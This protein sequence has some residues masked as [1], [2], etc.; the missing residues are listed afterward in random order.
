MILTGMG[1]LIGALLLACALF[2]VQN[3]AWAAGPI[4]SIES[5]RGSVTVERPG[6]GLIKGTVGLSVFEDDVLVTGAGSAVGVRFI[7][8]TSFGL[9]AGGHMV[10]D[11]FAYDPRADSGQG[12]IGVVAG[13]F[14]FVSGRLGKVGDDAL[15]VDT[16]TLTL[17]IRG[18]TV[19]GRVA[20]IGGMSKAVL[21]RDQG[22]TVGKIIAYNRSGYGVL[23]DQ[24]NF[25]TTAN[26]PNKVPSEPRLF[27]AAEIQEMAGDALSAMPT[28]AGSPAPGRSSGRGGASGS[29]GSN[30]A[31]AE[32][33]SEAVSD[34][35]DEAVNDSVDQSVSDAVNE[36]V[37]D[38]G[39]PQPPLNF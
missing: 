28:Q 20:P 6:G 2:T 34:A 27:S 12:V 23:I 18:T 33:T 5:A 13:S 36:A 11:E 31:A 37:D 3:F 15:S 29:G 1:R 21:L 10:L 4:G 25:G 22:G 8:G 26:D 32:A 30:D 35:T 38:D 9:G 24:A 7:D 39:F 17:G 16:P 19:A 14:A